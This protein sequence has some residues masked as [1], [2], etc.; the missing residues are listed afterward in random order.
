MGSLFEWDG[1]KADANR[2]QHGVT[3]EEAVSVFA[4]SLACI[5]DDPDH[6]AR[7]RREVV[8]GSSARGRLL[9]VVFTE[10]GGRVRII[11]ARR[12]TRRERKAHEE[13]AD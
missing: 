7:E 2:R 11:S 13:N 4:D 5:F 6:S 8:I 3:F 9:L 10:R 1:R 12:A